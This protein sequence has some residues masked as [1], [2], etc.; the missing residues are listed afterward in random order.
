[1]EDD[2]EEQENEAWGE[3]E[4]EE[5]EGRGGGGAAARATASDKARKKQIKYVVTNGAVWGEGVQRKRYAGGVRK[6]LQRGG[7]YSRREER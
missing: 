7:V 6:G 1:M 3:E 2:E 5:E 4:E